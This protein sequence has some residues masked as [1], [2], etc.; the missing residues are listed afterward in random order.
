MSAYLIYDMA[1]QLHASSL[2]DSLVVTGGTKSMVMKK[3]ISI[4][5]LLTLSMAVYAQNDVTK[6]LGIPVEGTKAEMIQKLKAKGFQKPITTDALV[7]EFNGEKVNVFVV[8]NRKS[9]VCRIMLADVNLVDKDGIKS[10][11]N[12]LCRQFANNPKYISMKNYSIGEGEDVTYEIAVHKKRYEAI[13]YQRPTVID[14][15]TIQREIRPI[16][17]SRY[18]EAQLANPTREIQADIQGVF[19]EHVMRSC[20]GRPVWFMVS[21]Y[22][23]K[24]YITMFYDNMSDQKTTKSLYNRTSRANG[25]DL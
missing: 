5:M 23:G 7:G 9:K 18:T 16:L 20:L 19:N 11:F 12:R 4:V 17:L 8:M 15:A 24:Y 6:F 13:F 14:S 21:E 22:D 2:W 25:D 10:R 3:L 1:F